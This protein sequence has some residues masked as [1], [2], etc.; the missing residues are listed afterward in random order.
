MLGEY[1]KENGTEQ[2]LGTEEDIQM[3][4]YMFNSKCHKEV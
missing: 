1:E 2:K 3:T 4:D